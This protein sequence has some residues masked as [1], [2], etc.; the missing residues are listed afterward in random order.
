MCACIYGQVADISA[1]ENIH[2]LKCTKIKIEIFCVLGNSSWRKNVGGTD[3]KGHN[4]SLLTPKC[5]FNW[6]EKE[7]EKQKGIWITVS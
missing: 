1:C 5:L 3:V 4:H 6:K 2:K 7:K